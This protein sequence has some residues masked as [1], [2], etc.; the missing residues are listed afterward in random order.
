MGVMFDNVVRITRDGISKDVN[1]SKIKKPLVEDSG[2][3]DG[4]LREK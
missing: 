4:D 3:K 2:A 1:V